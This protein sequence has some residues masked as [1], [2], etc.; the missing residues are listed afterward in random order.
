MAALT[1]FYGQRGRSAGLEQF[2]PNGEQEKARRGAD[3]REELDR[4]S[5]CLAR[6][7]PRRLQ[8]IEPR[9]AG[10]AAYLSGLSLIADLEMT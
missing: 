5:P 2:G 3:V 10:E 1:R 4:P 9:G 6:L 7:L 8:Q